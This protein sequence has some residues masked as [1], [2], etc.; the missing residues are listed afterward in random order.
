MIRWIHK[1][2]LREKEG[3]LIFCIWFLVSTFFI[4]TFKLN[5]PGVPMCYV[6]VFALISKYKQEAILPFVSL[7]VIFFIKH[8]FSC[9]V[10]LRQKSVRTVWLHEALK[11]FILSIYMSLV[12]LVWTGVLAKFFSECAYSWDTYNSHF[13]MITG[14]EVLNKLS[15]PLF[16]LVYFISNVF[17]IYVSSLIILLCYWLF[18][19]Y[20]WGYLFVATYWF[21]MTEADLFDQYC[22]AEFSVWLKA[23]KWHEQLLYPVLLSL[24]LIFAGFILVKNKEFGLKKRGRKSDQ[25]E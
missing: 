17:L 5:Y 16:L 8:D 10:V 12:V 11:L 23:I 20:I 21:F 2:I 24:V 15:Y 25:D 14:G 4:M 7:S 18:G 19:T 3:K 6:D 1:S 9:N 13:A 22:T